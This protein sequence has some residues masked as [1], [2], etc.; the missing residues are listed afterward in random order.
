MTR[1]YG[2]LFQWGSGLELI[3][4]ADAAYAPNDEKRKSVSGAAVMCGDAAIQW[5]SGTE[6]CT[7]LC[8]SEAEYVAMIEEFR[9]ALFKRHV[10]HF[11]TP[12]LRIRSCRFGG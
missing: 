10:W 5:I 8:S 4:Y 1:S 7:T 11:L 2:D 12:D 3:V 9:E 6:K